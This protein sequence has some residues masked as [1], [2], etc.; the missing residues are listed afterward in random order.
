MAIFRDG[1]VHLGV[2]P[3]SKKGETVELRIVCEYMGVCVGGD[4]K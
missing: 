1:G 3:S 4:R 2:H